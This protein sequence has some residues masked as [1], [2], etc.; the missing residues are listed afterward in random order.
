MDGWIKIH[1]KILEWEW[2]DDPYVFRVFF[3]FLMT[4]NYEDKKWH[5]IIIKRGQ[6]VCSYPSI[7]EELAI[8]I[9]NVRTAIS[10]LKSTGEL[11]HKPH[12]RW[13]VVTV[14]KYEDYQTTNRQTN[15][16]LTGN[17]QAT[18]NNIRNKEYKNILSKDNM[19]KLPNPEIDLIITLY[20]KQMGF[21]PTDKYPRRVAQNIRQ[22]I[23]SFIKEMEPYKKFTFN[24]VVSRSFEWYM[25]REE[26]KGETLDVF[27]RKIRILLDLTRTKYKGGEV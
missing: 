10:K 7:A 22:I 14:N 1:R 2:Y 25:N 15:S 19:A 20:K 12:S 16:Q 4:A 11:T 13:S 26:I 24:E 6:R 23:N 18:N 17:Q 5:G 3:H 8:T 21:E 9:Q 27:K